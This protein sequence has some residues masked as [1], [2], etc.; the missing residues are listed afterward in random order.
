[1]NVVNLGVLAELDAIAWIVLA[2]IVS[3]FGAATLLLLATRTAAD[4]EQTGRACASVLPQLEPAALATLPPAAQ[5]G[6]RLPPWELASAYS[7]TRAPP[8]G[9]RAQRCPEQR[10]ILP[11]LTAPAQ[12][13]LVLCVPRSNRAQAAC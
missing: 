12:M 6:V 3:L 7:A 11:R 1:M 13:L 10:S 2:I 9:N 5:S 8:G 4:S